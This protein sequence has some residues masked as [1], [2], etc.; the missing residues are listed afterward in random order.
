MTTHPAEEFDLTAL[1]NLL[2]RRRRL[3]ACF[4]LGGA[5]VFG[6]IAFTAKPVF[7]AEVVVTESQQRGMGATTGLA[8]QL[9]GLASLAGVNLPQGAFGA[10]QQYGAVLESRHLAEEFIRR[11]GLLPLLRHVDR[12][13][14]SLWLAVDDFKKGVLT[15]RKDMRKGTT[16][17]SVEWTDP[18]IASRWANGYVALANELIR[19]HAI[20]DS[21]RNVAY[22]NEQLAKTNDVELRKVMYNL[23]ENE[24][25]TLMLA[26]GRDEF[27]F[28]VV[29]PA[30]TPER[31]IGPHRLLMTLVGLTLGLGLGAIVAFARDRIVR[32]RRVTAA[33]AGERSVIPLA[34]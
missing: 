21:T 22:L 23:I 19:K 11:N 10:G 3:V 20:E 28:E 7:R 12:P 33:A 29:D 16:T 15:V 1:F 24:T 18:A 6:V 27:A 9:G 26:N 31:K 8:A 4:A 34:K 13:D 32:H 2:W 17:V 25:K 5:L 14:S 30:V